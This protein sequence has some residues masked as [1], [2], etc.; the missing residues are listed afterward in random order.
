MPAKKQRLH[1][2]K[3]ATVI[4]HKDPRISAGAGSA[5]NRDRKTPARQ[6]DAGVSL[7]RMQTNTDRDSAS[8]SGMAR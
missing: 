2:K 4:P 8:T 7:W 5:I 3:I 6:T 1:T